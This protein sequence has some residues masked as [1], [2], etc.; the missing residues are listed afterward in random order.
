[1]ILLAFIDSEFD[2]G[3]LPSFLYPLCYMFHRNIPNVS[4][5]SSVNWKL[6]L[7]MKQLE[8]FLLTLFSL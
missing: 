6:E 7:F 2:D 5:F 4:F 3:T 1:M 8:L